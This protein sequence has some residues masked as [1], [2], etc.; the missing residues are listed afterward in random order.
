M[1]E[2]SQLKEQNKKCSQE[3]A[4][5]I[6]DNRTLRGEKEALAAKVS[7]LNEKIDLKS[8]EPPKQNPDVALTE[9]LRK[10]ELELQSEKQRRRIL[11]ESLDKEYEGRTN[12]M[13]LGYPMYGFPLPMNYGTADK[14]EKKARLLEVDLA[15]ERANKDV[16]EQTV[17]EL[18]V[19]LEQ[20]KAAAQSHSESLI[21]THEKEMNE[22]FKV[23]KAKE[24]EVVEL[25]QIATQFHIVANELSDVKELL[26]KKSQLADAYEHEHALLTKARE[27]ISN[28]ENLTS[29]LRLALAKQRECL[30]QKTQQYDN[31]LE[32]HDR[33]KKLHNEV[34][35]YY[36]S[37][38]EQLQAAGNQAAVELEELKSAN[39]QVV[40]RL[41][42]K[43]AHAKS[44]HDEKVSRLEDD[45]AELSSSLQNEMEGL[46]SD[47]D[48]SK[49]HLKKTLE[50]LEVI[51]I[52][53]EDLQSQV[54]QLNQLAE[55]RKE[56]L[57]QVVA[58]NEELKAE[59]QGLRTMSERRGAEI[60]ED[61]VSIKSL[62]LEKSSLEIEMDRLKGELAD[63]QQ[64]ILMYEKQ[65]TDL[66]RVLDEMDSKLITVS[67]DLE[68][69][70]AALTLM[71]D[72]LASS[73]QTLGAKEEHIK[74]VSEKQAKLESAYDKILSAVIK[75][76][77][78]LLPEVDFSDVTSE[79]LED[80]KDHIAT[81][82]TVIREHVKECDAL[83]REKEKQ[84]DAVNFDMT[85]TLREF[86]TLE[87]KY[88]QSRLELLEYIEARKN[89]QELDQDYDELLVHYE[90]TCDDLEKATADNH[91][92]TEQLD[93]VELENSKLAK[94]TKSQQE[95][96]ASLNA[97][98]QQHLTNLRTAE[99]QR[100][101]FQSRLKEAVDDLEE[102]ENERNQL[103]CDLDTTYTDSAKLEE[104]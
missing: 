33:M 94:E 9:K 96:L 87:S 84:I 41:E 5:L 104:R 88:R 57:M 100:D 34:A 37:E 11:E 46:K 25:S 58:S 79:S 71:S 31:L 73:N 89:Q 70:E 99:E 20:E 47:L 52:S 36:E 63:A 14:S 56:E 65:S 32:E 62:T 69:K 78:A 51:C 48:Q 72:K 7:T 74:Q 91:H 26:E 2:I 82:T 29:D 93:K 4:M 97:A 30:H 21:T 55:T 81:L 23:L 76:L 50:E 45:L 90:R 19:A 13:Q 39:R 3:N 103:R 86:D 16:L 54:K 38:I 40:A 12:A 102:L 68:D 80:K 66:E 42:E 101:V 49:L 18:T 61:K 10:M 8:L 53:N 24:D 1:N 27:D 92:L 75:Q 98:I 22:V 59:I 17:S 28:E 77:E 64:E 43:M 95:E 44:A 6:I 67:A 60:N 83:M 85:S 15:A 35:S